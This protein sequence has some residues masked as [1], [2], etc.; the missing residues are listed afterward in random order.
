M[1]HVTDGAVPELAQTHIH[2]QSSLPPT[3]RVN[4]YWFLRLLI[5]GEEFVPQK[6]GHPFLHDL[7][8][9]V[10]VGEEGRRDRDKIVSSWECIALIHLLW[11]CC[12]T[13]VAV[14]QSS[15]GRVP[16]SCE[17]DNIWPPW[18]E[19][20]CIRLPFSKE[21]LIFVRHLNNCLNVRVRTWPPQ[22]DCSKHSC[23]RFTS[24]FLFFFPPS[25]SL[26]FCPISLLESLHPGSFH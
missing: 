11:V 12:F 21:Q 6:H 14:V 18:K 7:P 23:Q 20:Y 13:R 22:S 17:T 4:P 26:L 2:T 19:Q 9:C 15:L 1:E 16:S 10:W 24:M 5:E 3:K 25:N 8:Q